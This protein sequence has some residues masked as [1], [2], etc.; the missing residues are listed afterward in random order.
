[1]RQTLGALLVAMLAVATTGEAQET[2]PDT[3]QEARPEAKK[4]DPVVVTATTIATPADQLG[5]ALNVI[6]ATVSL[7]TA[8]VNSL[9]HSPSQA[10]VVVVTHAPSRPDCR[11][12]P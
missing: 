3:T 8:V 5:V 2:K 12:G 11:T 6:T 4:V 10:V 1:M 7:G 9:P